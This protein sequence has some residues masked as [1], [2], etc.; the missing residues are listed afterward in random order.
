MQREIDLRVSELQEALTEA[1]TAD[2]PIPAAEVLAIAKAKKV[3]R[4]ARG[5]VA[6]CAGTGQVARVWKRA[7]CGG[8]RVRCGRHAC[9]GLRRLRGFLVEP[10]PA[11]RV[12]STVDP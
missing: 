3:G 12:F 4:G 1:I 11:S 6:A 10:C 7:L 2:P 5:C 9:G 8:G